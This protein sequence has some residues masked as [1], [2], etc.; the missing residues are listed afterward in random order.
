MISSLRA[1][2]V[3]KKRLD[4]IESYRP[5]VQ[6]SA[7]FDFEWIPYEGKYEHHKTRI[8]EACLCTNWGR[9]DV[10]HISAYAYAGN[11]DEHEKSLI[12]DILHYLNQ[13]P[14]TFGWYSTGVAVY[15][16]QTGRFSGHNSDLF[17][18]HQRCLL[19]GLDSP[20]EV[21]QKKTYAYARLK[22]PDRKHIDLCKVFEK[23]IVQKNLFDE[24]YRTTDLESI[25]Q[26]LLGIG[27]YGKLDAGTTDICSLPVE[28]Q[29]RY[30]RRDS[31]LTMRLAQYNNCLV[32][33]MMKVFAGYAG[34]LD[35]YMTCHTDVGIWWANRYRTMLES[36]ECTVSFTP[37]YRLDKQAIGGG[38]HI[39]SAKGL[40]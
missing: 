2:P 23:N 1:S 19:H 38:E 8:F 35:Y 40:S 30:V 3:S 10:L 27:K 16:E 22:N 11:P 29:M 34:G 31:E 13:F 33:R 20:V 37:N 36:E 5:E 28:E 17:M 26:A 15:D 18:L 9:R 39:P 4:R 32:L 21:N 12:Q 25:S 6:N 24:Q 7:S 14:L